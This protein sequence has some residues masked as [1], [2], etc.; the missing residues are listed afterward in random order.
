M[1]TIRVPRECLLGEWKGQRNQ[2]E[3][4]TISI[5]LTL[6]LETKSCNISNNTTLNI[7]FGITL[8][9]CTSN[10]INSNLISNVEEGISSDRGN[11][12]TVV[13]NT[14]AHSKIFFTTEITQ[15]AKM[16]FARALRVD[17]GASAITALALAYFTLR[18]L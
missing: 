4:S 12:N 18:T 7:R 14:R 10:T 9:D 13:G 1:R 8:R 15:F 17:Q 3:E 11:Y 2:I 16:I 6:S 5:I